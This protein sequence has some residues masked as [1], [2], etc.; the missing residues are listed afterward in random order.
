[1]IETPTSLPPL[2][3]LFLGAGASCELGL[4]LVWELTRELKDW[5]TPSKLRSF[6][7]GWRLQGGGHPDSVVEQLVRLLGMPALHYESILGNLEVHARRPEQN[8]EHQEYG[9]LYAWLIEVVY[10]MLYLKHNARFANE[11]SRLNGIARLAA[12][13]KPLWI[14]SV[15]HDLAIECL[16][17]MHSIVLN[18]GFSPSALKLPKRN[19]QG[20]RTGELSVEVLTEE[21]IDRTGIPFFQPGHEGI[22]LLKIHGSMD[23]FA[24]R[25]GKDLLRILPEDSSAA[26]ILRALKSSNEE[27]VYVHPNA[28][29]GKAKTTNEITY[30][31]DAGEM[32]FLRRTLLSGAFKFDGR[33]DQV[34]PKKMLQHFK[35]HLN[36]L[37]RL[38]CVG[39]GFGDA[40]INNVFREWLEFTDAR[41]LEIVGPGM[42][43]VPSALLHLA[44]QIDLVD[45]K[46]GAYFDAIS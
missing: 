26:G 46:A 7:A 33:R 25:D 16:C 21:Q 37:S 23:V 24:F 5:L 19:A 38:A 2:T 10:M 29:G 6:N 44:P 34:M 28:I 35:A 39:Y 11:V 30:A 20:A 8:S 27:L 1:M 4:P 9:H 18:C 3:G 43:S 42:T 36:Y 40:H 22:N 31:D 45:S 12:K 17:A 13:N 14:F 15:N 32:Q 41:R